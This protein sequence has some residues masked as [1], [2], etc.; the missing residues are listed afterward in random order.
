MHCSQKEGTGICSDDGGCL[1]DRGA[2]LW[3]QRSSKALHFCCCESYHMANRFPRSS[4]ACGTPG[5]RSSTKARGY[6]CRA[7]SNVLPG[8]SC[9]NP[10]L[11]LEL[12]AQNE[13]GEEDSSQGM[14]QRATSHWDEHAIAQQIS[15]ASAVLTHQSVCA[16]LRGVAVSDC[17]LGFRTHCCLSRKSKLPVPRCL[18]LA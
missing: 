14:F 10:H 2:S 16:C 18:L 1:P 9:L 17:L 7:Q 4:M 3:G 12:G 11:S 8:A 5:S 15:S 6:H 13:Q